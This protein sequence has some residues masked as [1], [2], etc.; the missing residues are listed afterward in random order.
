MCYKVP[1]KCKNKNFVQLKILK[2]KKHKAKNK[3]NRSIVC[4]SQIDDF[5]L[6]SFT[7]SGLQRA[8]NDF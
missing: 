7:E 8:L 2:A 3:K 6:L 4:C 5:V 1:K